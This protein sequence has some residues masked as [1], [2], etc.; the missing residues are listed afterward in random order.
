MTTEID[1]L[2]ERIVCLTPEQAE[3]LEHTVSNLRAEQARV[4]EERIAGLR[5]KD[6]WE[7]AAEI[8]QIAKPDPDEVLGILKDA[9]FVRGADMMDVLREAYRAGFSDSAEGWN[10]ENRGAEVLTHPVFM[11]TMERVIARIVKGA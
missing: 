5:A 6:D 8:C 9:G 3:E 1:D 10:F 2:A 7:L 4:K 11:D